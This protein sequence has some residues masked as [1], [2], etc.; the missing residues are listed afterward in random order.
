M[1]LRKTWPSQTF[2]ESSELI[3]ICLMTQ[4]LKVQCPCQDL[5]AKKKLASKVFI[6][7]IYPG[8]QNY[9]SFSRKTISRNFLSKMACESTSNLIWNCL[10]ICLKMRWNMIHLQADIM[11]VVVI[12]SLMIMFQVHVI[13]LKRPIFSL[14]LSQL[15]M[16][17]ILIVLR[18]TIS[19]KITP[20]FWN[21][22]KVRSNISK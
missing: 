13:T 9:V 11:F 14:N 22:S 21:W 7:V 3:L 15:W 6:C 1:I 5:K 16:T 8:I 4:N 2:V 12:W 17:H 19:E 10:L 20:L 18:N